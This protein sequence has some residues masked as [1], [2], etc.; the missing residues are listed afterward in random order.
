[1]KVFLKVFLSIIVVA[2]IFCVSV[3]I[4][5]GITGQNFVEVLKAWFTKPPVE[6]ALSLII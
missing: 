4:Y 3:L 1:M 6:E 2:L 5:G